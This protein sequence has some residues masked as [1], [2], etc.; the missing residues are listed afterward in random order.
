MFNRLL[1]QEEVGEPCPA[2][3]RQK[4]LPAGVQAPHVAARAAGGGPHGR[5]RASATGAEPDAEPDLQRQRSAREAA[6]R[7]QE[8]PGQV[9]AGPRGPQPAP[10]DQQGPG[11]QGPAAESGHQEEKKGEAGSAPGERQEEETGE[12]GGEEGPVSGRSTW[13]RDS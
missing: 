12:V 8:P 7:H 2:D 9:P 11:L 4:P 6:R 10:G 13:L 1:F 3:A 5:R